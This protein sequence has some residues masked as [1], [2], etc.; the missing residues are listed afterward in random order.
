MDL[1]SAYSPPVGDGVYFV[2]DNGPHLPPTFVDATLVDAQL[3][4]SV[5]LAVD[6]YY[7]WW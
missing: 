2:T 7:P 1:G 6:V 3:S 5:V 4:R